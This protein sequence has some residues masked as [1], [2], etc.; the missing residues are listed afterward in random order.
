MKP[1][2]LAGL[3][4]STSNGGIRC[5]SSG[6]RV[7]TTSGTDPHVTLSARSCA[8]RIFREDVF[9]PREPLMRTA[10]RTLPNH[11]AIAIPTA[12]SGCN[13]NPRAADLSHPVETPAQREMA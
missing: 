8:V 1:E 10:F 5:Y 6:P 13:L 2:L 7:F 12:L 4:P 3:S 9:G 11:T